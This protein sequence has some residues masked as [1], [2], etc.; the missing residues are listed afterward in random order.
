MARVSLVLAS[1][2]GL[3][4]SGQAAAQ[5][6]AE[7]QRTAMFAR[8][9]AAE[10]S[11]AWTP[12]PGDPLSHFTIA[13]AKLM[14]SAV[15]V[16][17]FD[18]E[19]ARATLGDA[20]ALA[21]VAHRVKSGAPVIDRQRREVRVTTH[22]GLTRTA[23]FIGD[24]GCVSLPEGSNEIAFKPKP[25]PRNLPN[26]ATTAWPMGD[27]VAPNAAAGLD[28]AKIKAVVDAA[29]APDDALT[30]AF[31]VTWK[32]QIIAERYGS[33]ANASTP[34][35]GWSMGKSIAASL[36]GVQMQQGLYTLDQPAPIPEWQGAGDKRQSIRIRDILNMSS[37]LRVRA[38]QDPDYAYDGGYPDH[39]YYYTGNNAFAYAASR[40]Q[41]WPPG[42]VG[43][44]RNTDPVLINY[45]IQLGVKKQGGDYLTFPQRALFDR[46]GIR[47]AVLETDASGNF[48]TQ[49]YDL[50]AGRDWARL[51]NLYLQDGV[52]NGERILPEGYVK[53]VSTLAPAWVAD[54]RPIYGGLFW[55]NGDGNL[56][57]PRDAYAMQGAGGQYT[58]IIPSHDLVIVR[59]GRFAGSRPGTASLNRALALLMA[60]VPASDK[61]K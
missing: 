25:V 9:K 49:G 38:E 26:A 21:A 56:P 43:R 15:F 40:L 44:Y 46:I 45:L 4:M 18:P 34:L 42:V 31:V 50:L 13:Y 20:N 6:P 48:L 52:W 37:G 61:G 14:C 55:V 3:F 11:N 54:G 23:R 36:M 5:T 59:L 2:I 16:S 53:F 22:S 29:F 57:I 19:F 32:G 47:S 51:G 10:I 7:A 8:A 12:A 39:W 1:V 41:Q 17:G 60:A 27:I 28:P 35:E 33:G 24:Q 58:I 30:Q